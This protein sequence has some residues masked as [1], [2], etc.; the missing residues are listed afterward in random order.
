MRRRTR[1]LSVVAAVAVLV[2]AAALLHLYW[3]QTAWVGSPP[4]GRVS[5]QPARVL[6]VVYSRTGNT[7]AAAKVVA[8]YFDADLV[9]IEA[10]L[11]PRDD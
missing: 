4:Y 10:P 2:G 1:V 8:E 5:D 11:P 9:E 6:V 3:T 7:L